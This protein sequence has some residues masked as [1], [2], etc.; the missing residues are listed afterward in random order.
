M[1]LDATRLIEAEQDLMN[2]TTD[3][4]GWLNNMYISLAAYR[5]LEDDYNISS[6][7]DYFEEL[8]K[9]VYKHCMF[10]KCCETLVAKRTRLTRDNE[11]V[12]RKAIFLKRSGAFWLKHGRRKHSDASVDTD[13][14]SWED[15]AA[16]GWR[17]D[18]WAPYDPDYEG[19]QF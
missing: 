7:V 6:Y 5:S 8:G 11:R 1:T 19:V 15:I 12:R 2:I 17:D 16:D 3:G 18:G 13:E 10:V 4:D 14:N 9:S